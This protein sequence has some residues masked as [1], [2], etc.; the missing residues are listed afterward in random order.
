MCASEVVAHQAAL[1]GSAMYAGRQA[2]GA[3]ATNTLASSRQLQSGYLF[4]ISH[5][6]HMHTYNAADSSAAADTTDVP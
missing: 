2:T 3:G 6:K 1:R 5:D 4:A